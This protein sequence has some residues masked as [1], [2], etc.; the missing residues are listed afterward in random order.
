MKLSKHK[1]KKINSTNIKA[2]QFAKK[3]FS[4]LV[5]IAE[6]QTTGKGRFKRKWFSSKNGLYFSLLL[7]E[8]NIER[9]KY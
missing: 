7:K 4:N 2:K 5:I 6:E 3:G 1:F 8:K 9:I